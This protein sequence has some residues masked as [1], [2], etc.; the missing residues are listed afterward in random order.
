MSDNKWLI[1][2]GVVCI[3]CGASGLLADNAGSDESK[4]QK[5]IETDCPECGTKLFMVIEG[6]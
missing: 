4:S 3:L 2:I 5:V 1:V 6:E